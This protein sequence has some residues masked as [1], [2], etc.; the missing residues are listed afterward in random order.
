M[1]AAKHYPRAPIT[2]ALVDLRVS[3]PAPR[4]LQTLKSLGD[5]LGNSYP[6]TAAR[7]MFQAEFKVGGSAQ[8][9]QTTVGYIFHT[10]DRS[11]AVQA[12]QDGFTFSR[13]APYETWDTLVAE[14]MRL[15]ALFVQVTGPERVTRVAVRYINQLNL[16][17]ESNTDLDFEKYLKTIPVIGSDAGQML[18]SF[19]MRLILPQADL[20]ATL[21]LSEALIPPRIPRTVAVIL[22]LDLFR[23][24]L[25][26]DPGSE[27]IWRILD[28]FRSRKNTY[29]EASITDLTRELFK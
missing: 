18:E 13:F 15:W 3:Y 23:E 14:A 9:H 10:A 7:D 11:Q 27:E 29:F 16:P 12:R 2:E 22:D 25:S 6:H 28:S 17:L 8:S 19:F 24:G 5:R 26:I 20:G 21:V 1:T 4:D